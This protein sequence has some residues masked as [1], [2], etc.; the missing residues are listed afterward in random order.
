ME[1]EVG[2]VGRRRRRRRLLLQRRRRGGGRS[3]SRSPPSVADPNAEVHRRGARRRAGAGRGG[4]RRGGRARL[5]RGQRRGGGS[6]RGGGAPVA[7]SVAAASRRD[8]PARSTYSTTASDPLHPI[9]GVAGRPRSTARRI[10]RRIPRRRRCGERCGAGGTTTRTPTTPRRPPPPRVGN[11]RF[12]SSR[13]STTASLASSGAASV[14]PAMDADIRDAARAIEEARRVLDREL[15]SSTGIRRRM[16]DA[17]DAAFRASRGDACSDGETAAVL[18]PGASERRG[19]PGGGTP[20]RPG[21]D[22]EGGGT[23]GG[24]WRGDLAARGCGREHG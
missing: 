14:L 4:E 5:R 10:P 15:A 24:G 1:R 23:A 8:R 9:V 6:G 3:E 12:G 7:G 13:R 18:S 16:D 2:I 17:V 19:R 20:G 21:K 22:E 11:R